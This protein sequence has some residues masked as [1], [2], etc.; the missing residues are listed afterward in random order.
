MKRSVTKLINNLLSKAMPKLIDLSKI[1]ANRTGRIRSRGVPTPWVSV[2]N[3]KKFSVEVGKLD[4]FFALFGIKR[5][6][7]TLAEFIPY[8]NKQMKRYA[9]HQIIRMGKARDQGNHRVF[10]KIA[11]TIMK[12]SNVFRVMCMNHVFNQ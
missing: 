8:K 12:R 5:T 3:V 6:H 10:F 1:R 7:N 2:P 9:E 11:D 4:V